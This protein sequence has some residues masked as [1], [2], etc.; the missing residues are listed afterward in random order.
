MESMDVVMLLAYAPGRCPAVTS[1]PEPLGWE[2][3]PQSRPQTSPQAVDFVL[4]NQGGAMEVKVVQDGKPLPDATV[5]LSLQAL[6]RWEM[7]QGLQGGGP[8]EDAMWRILMPRGK[9]DADGVAR[10]ENLI[11]GNYRI[12]VCDPPIYEYDQS[13]VRVYQYHPPRFPAGEAAGVSVNR[14][15][16]ARHCLAIYNPEIKIP[17]QVFAAKGTPLADEK[18]HIRCPRIGDIDDPGRWGNAT[19]DAQGIGAE[20]FDRS[21]L[22]RWKLFRGYTYSN[23]ELAPWDEASSV[24]AASRLLNVKKPVQLTERHLDAA[25]VNVR[26]LDASGRPVRGFA[27]VD[28]PRIS[29]YARSAT[30][31][32]GAAQLQV[33]H[34]GTHRVGGWTDGFDPMFHLF[35]PPP[36][37]L[38][39]V[40]LEA[41]LPD[42]A[43]LRN[44]CAFP[45]EPFRPEPG[46]EATIVLKAQLVGYVRGQLKPPAGKT[47]R[48]Y[49][50]HVDNQEEFGFVAGCR[51]QARC[52]AFVAGPFLP[53]KAAL[54]VGRGKDGWWL[55]E[56][57]GEQE[58]TIAGGQVTEM[59]VRPVPAP[60][61]KPGQPRE[62]LVDTAGRRIPAAGNALLCGNV[63]MSDGKTPAMG[64][65]ISYLSPEIREQASAPR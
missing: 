63:R 43:A 31:G 52:G 61:V 54:L 47:T 19:L 53:G 44:R 12:N 58:V 9:T 48:D 51:Y 3:D 34:I 38:R 27:W 41:P 2:M 40:L 65:T 17:V 59:E 35:D 8:V 7:L 46:T 36:A 56:P 50:V 23:G 57:I 29:G 4:T 45:T 16:V 15:V 55:G 13:G 10:F 30:D 62:V 33:R 20:T 39:R 64:A 1:P 42:G 49:C 21:G 60:L 11:P 37:D 14:G 26:L 32:S 28:A 24:V 22:W 5:D 6:S 25:K 18:P